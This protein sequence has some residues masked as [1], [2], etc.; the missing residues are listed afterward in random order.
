MVDRAT[1]TPERHRLDNSLAYSRINSIRTSCGNGMKIY[2]NPVTK[3]VT[4]GA[5]DVSTISSVEIFDTRGVLILRTVR[6]TSNKIHVEKLAAGIYVVEI[7]TTSGVSES[8][9]IFKK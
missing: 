6:P 4:L 2:P 1:G 7:T 3:S 8:E 5:V 9:K